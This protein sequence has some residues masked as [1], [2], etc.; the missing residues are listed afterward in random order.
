MSDI[1]AIIDFETTGLSPT[2]GARATEIAAVI[3]ENGQIV[4]RYQSLMNA[5]VRI[6][7]QIEAL[8]GISNAMIREAPAA[9]RVMQAVAD[10]VGDYPLVAHNAA[11]DSRF[12]DAELA[13]IGQTRRQGFLCSLLLA[14]RVLPQA[15][16]HRLES[17][18]RLLGLPVS[19]RFHRA[20]ADAEMTAG[21]LQRLREEFCSRHCLSHAP[22]EL[23]AR[24]QKLPVRNIEAFVA[25]E[26][27]KGG[28]GAVQSS[29]PKQAL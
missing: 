29:G 4:D 5:G 27:R 3:V 23:L 16:S 21:L 20:L 25:A 22:L 2:Q 13:R 7:G 12:W 9:D 26:K 11:F 6:P 1:V 14:R 28:A 19:G 18:I 17:L 15:S 24:L 8:T 10:F